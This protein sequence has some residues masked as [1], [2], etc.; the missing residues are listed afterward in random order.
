MRA[1]PSLNSAFDESGKGH[2]EFEIDTGGT[3]I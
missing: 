1:C 2:L 3:S